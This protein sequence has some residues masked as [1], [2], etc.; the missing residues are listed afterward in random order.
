MT[1][2]R[3]QSSQ[4]WP[5]PHSLMLGFRARYE[6][7]DIVLDETEIAEAA[8]FRREDLPRLPN[9]ISISRR[10]IDEWLHDAPAV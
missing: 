2:V 7:G 4:P 9:S 3:Y 6:S 8:W 1:D 5:F 10:L